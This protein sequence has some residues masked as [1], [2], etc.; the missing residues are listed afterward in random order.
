[1]KSNSNKQTIEQSYNSLKDCSS[2]DLFEKLEKEVQKQKDNG[3][4]DYYGLVNSIE[5]IKSY[6]PNETYENMMRLLE[7]FK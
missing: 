7:N 6:L 5:R 3:S 4:F 1:M 2:E